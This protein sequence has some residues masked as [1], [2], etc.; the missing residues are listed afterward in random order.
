MSIPWRMGL[1]P[2]P[3]ASGLD[4]ALQKRSLPKA[5]LHPMSQ[6]IT[7]H[8]PS[9]LSDWLSEEAERQGVTPQRLVQTKLET[10][11]RKS[12]AK[13]FMKLTGAVNGPRNLS[14]RKGFSK[15]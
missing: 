14:Q 5:T 7:I 2:V 13:P 10:E 12:A 1:H 3:S 9:G 11:R 4:D 15:A 8:I 6:P